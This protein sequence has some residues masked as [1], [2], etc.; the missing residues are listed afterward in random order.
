MHK[1]KCLLII[2]LLFASFLSRADKLSK[3]FEALRIYNYFEAKRI[4]GQEIKKHPA[5]AS[6]GLSVMYARNDNPFSDIDS[7]YRYITLSEKTYS[8]LSEKKKIT[9]RLYNVQPATID[10]LR[11]LIHSKA[12]E[13][14]RSKNSVKEWNRFI[15]MYVNADQCF[16]AIE[17][18]NS[19]AFSEAKKL[20]SVDAF[21]SY[22]ESYPLAREIEEAK[23]LYALTLFQ[24]STR[25]NTIA[26]FAKFLEDQ[27]DSPFAEHAQNSIYKLSVPNGTI[28]EN[29]DFIKKFPLNPNTGNA[30]SSIYLAYTADY[31]YSSILKFKNDF[32]YHP[33]DE[34]VEEDLALSIKRVLPYRID[35]KWGF[36]DSSGQIVIPCL[37]EWVEP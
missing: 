8:L 34:R 37:Y 36:I 10:S 13:Q 32:P 18:R 24:S 17:L 33:F 35:N 4:F 25:N 22:I 14:Y 2:A 28:K 19:L 27:P 12:F 15:D 1:L 6:F 9:Y 5:A 21:R 16:E 11:N 20:N 26:E 31:S 30:W 23:D 7:A 3:G 29:V